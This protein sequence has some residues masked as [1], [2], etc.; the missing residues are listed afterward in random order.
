MRGVWNASSADR[1]RPASSRR[2]EG[3]ADEDVVDPLPWHVHRRRD[4]IATPALRV[5]RAIA[6][7][8]P[9]VLVVGGP[10]V[11][12]GE[13]AEEADLVAVGLGVEVAADD[14]RHRVTLAAERRV[15]VQRAAGSADDLVD[16][17]HLRPPVQPVRRRRSEVAGENIEAGS[18]RVHELPR[19]ACRDRVRV[20]V[21]R[22]AVVGMV[23]DRP[24]RQ[25]RRAELQARGR[26]RSAR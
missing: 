12:R 13:A 23:L 18:V 6:G 22:E 9:G 17:Q 15:V 26:A 7:H 10:P 8:P 4:R 16:R 19:D 25:H 20:G 5:A 1:M 11:E 2:E 21:D 14:R 24:A 3:I